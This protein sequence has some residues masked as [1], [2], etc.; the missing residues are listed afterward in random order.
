MQAILAGADGPLAD[1]VVADHGWAGAAAQ[2]GL[3]V[4]G[5]ADTND[6]ALFVGAD[7][8]KLDVVVPL[9]DNVTPADYAPLA[10]Y[11]LANRDK[12]GLSRSE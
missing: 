5:F 3:P 8:G 2:H 1:L 9:D 4:L 12:A 10:A 7:E 6:P 11:L